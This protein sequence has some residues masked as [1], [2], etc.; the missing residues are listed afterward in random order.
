MFIFK[1]LVIWLISE[2]ET[3]LTIRIKV[4]EKCNMENSVVI[5]GREGSR[6]VGQLGRGGRG[7]R[8]DNN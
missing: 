5:A 1:F 3:M 4:T 6:E 8:G 7:C 2:Y